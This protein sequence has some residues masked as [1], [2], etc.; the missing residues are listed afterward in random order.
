[1]Q[2]YLITDNIYIYIYLSLGSAIL[3]ILLQFYEKHKVSE[4]FINVLM[5]ESPITVN[6]TDLSGLYFT[7]K[8]N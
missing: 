3:C 6:V 8:S 5:Q 1:M 2:V 7:L 4:I